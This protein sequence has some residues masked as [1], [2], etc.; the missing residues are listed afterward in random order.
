MQP[1]G[2]LTTDLAAS[3]RPV[4]PEA[5]TA[6]L[7]AIG[8]DVPAYAGA[9]DTQTGPVVRRGTEIALTR[10]L[11]LFGTDD[12]ALDVRS[13]RFYRRLGAGE[14]AQGRSLES[15]LSAYRIGARVAWE[16][17]SSAAVASGVETPALVSLA[18]AF[19]VY[20]DEL[21]GASAQGHASQAGVRDVL[22]SRLAQ[23]LL[24]G[25]A[26]TD[27]VGL[28][29][30]ADAAGW[31]IPERLAVAVV[32]LSPGREPTPPSDVLVSVE[33]DEAIAIL[34]DPSG[35][36][37]RQALE[38]AWEGSQVFVGTVRPVAEA[39]TSLAHARR[40]RRLV[41]QGRVPSTRV[42]AAADHLTELVV[43]ADAE[44]LAELDARV[45]SPLAQIKPV[46]REAL[47]D[48]LRAWLAFQGDRHQI[49]E[50]LHVHPQTVSYRHQRLRE[51]FGE[52]LQDPQERLALQLVLGL[53][54]VG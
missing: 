38:R 33:D 4:L 17:M 9:M 49:A 39:P 44:L 23:A 18:E 21:S 52:A 24:E 42:V 32:P 6:I 26:L 31:T 2:R 36:G 5:V 22:R 34:P 30:A 12:A 54:N 53:P 29:A 15:V 11:D 20:I 35:P 47:A 46:K 8:Q 7:A 41:A 37:R 45:L 3:L 14:S 43:A 28:Q 51:L 48:T 16:H 27:P 40:V 25:T 13:A 1:W 50:H 19:F 10:L